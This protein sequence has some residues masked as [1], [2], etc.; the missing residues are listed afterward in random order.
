MI[1]VKDSE[2]DEKDHVDS[3][4]PSLFQN[5][6]Q[7]T[8]EEGADIV[9]GAA[10]LPKGEVKP[11]EFVLPY[12]FGFTDSFY[13]KYS[14]HYIKTVVNIAYEQWLQRMT[15]RKGK[16]WICPAATETRDAGFQSKVKQLY[17]GG[18]TA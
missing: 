13:M 14:P 10:F 7:F 5:T 6:F 18:F 15:Y 4:Y 8:S 1:T 9:L 3:P 11:G 12:W 2:R 16:L 17:L